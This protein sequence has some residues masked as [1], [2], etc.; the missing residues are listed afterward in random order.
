MSTYAG[1]RR[2][3]ELVTAHTTCRCNACSRI[4]TLDLK[5]VTHFGGFAWQELAGRDLTSL[6][7]AIRE[8]V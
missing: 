1:F 8:A 6:E 2:R 3:R 7:Q 4:G 5:F